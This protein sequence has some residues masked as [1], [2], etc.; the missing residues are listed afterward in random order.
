MMELGIAAG[1]QI[2][3]KDGLGKVPQDV[4]HCMATAGV[5]EKEGRS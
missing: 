2:E 4:N 1:R 5:T 3:I